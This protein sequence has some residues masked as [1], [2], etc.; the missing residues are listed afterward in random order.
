MV[1]RAPILAVVIAALVAGG[2]ADRAAGGTTASQGQMVEPAPMAAPA[3]ALSSSWFCAGADDDGTRQASG[4]VVIANSGS[5]PASG[6]VTVVPS[7]GSAVKVPVQVGPHTSVAVPEK[8]PGGSPWVGAIVDVDAGSVAVSQTLQGLST[9]VSPCATS[10]SSMWYFATGQTRVNADTAI[11]LLNPYPSDAIVDLSFSTNQGIE[12]PQDFQG[13]DVPSGGLVSVPLG[14]HLRRRSS[15]ATTVKARTGRVVAW[16]TEWVVPAAPNSVIAGTPQAANPVSDPASP[17]VG[18]DAIL[19]AAAPATSWVW[20]DGL[21]GPGLDEQYVIFNPGN[22]TAQVR[23]S[24]G[25]QHGSAEPISLSIGPYQVVP[26]VSEA[27]ARIPSGVP[28]WAQITSVNGVG[29]VATRSVTANNAPMADGVPRTGWTRMPGGLISSSRWMVP[30]PFTGQTLQGWVIVQNPSTRPA[31][32]TLAQVK[33]GAPGGTAPL[34]SGSTT[35]APEGRLAVPVPAGITAP[36]LVTASTP[37][38]TEY[39]LYGGNGAA[40]ISASMAVPLS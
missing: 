20:P 38:Y 31:R 22:Q 33:E 19:G 10:G 36:I 35:V 16:E 27:Q 25:L 5:Q 23:F 8:V 40:G 32:V 37:V 14:S 6:M 30:A 2:L 15:I 39:D 26:I 34:A 13:I 9:S 4:Q 1:R 29:V 12:Q 3:D 24:V 17:V 21:A 11:Q 28:H 18:V 7:V